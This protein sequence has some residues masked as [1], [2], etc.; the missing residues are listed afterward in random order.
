MSGGRFMPEMTRPKTWCQNYRLS[1]PGVKQFIVRGGAKIC[2]AAAARVISLRMS[3]RTL[4]EFAGTLVNYAR[5]ATSQLWKWEIRFRGAVMEGKLDLAGRPIVSVAYDSRLIL[6]DQVSLFS[7]M[8]SN[9]LGCFQP[10]VLRT[11]AQGAELR[12]NRNVGL[13]GTV[14]CAGRS[15]CVGEGTIFGAG[16]LVIDNDFHEWA[17]SRGWKTEFVRG[18]RPISIGRG[19]FVGARAIILK[20]VT[21][22]DRAVIGAGAVVTRDVPPGCLAAGN[23]AKIL[24]EWAG[25]PVPNTEK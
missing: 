22:G 21:I 13:S 4:A 23:P 14:I 16:A 1:G 18:A 25:K 19:V 8:R 7:A 20:G 5:R 9:P 12:L 17:A 15:I 6:G 24:G 10:C 3:E 2:E 11:L